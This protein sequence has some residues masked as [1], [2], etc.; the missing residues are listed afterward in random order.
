MDLSTL[1]SALNALVAL[2]IFADQSLCFT[3]KPFASRGPIVR[4]F[5]VNEDAKDGVSSVSADD[6]QSNSTASAQK[7]TTEFYLKG[8][9]RTVDY[10]VCFNCDD[11]PNGKRRRQNVVVR[12]PSSSEKEQIYRSNS[13]KDGVAIP[14]NKNNNVPSSFRDSLSKVF[15]PSFDPDN[16]VKKK[17]RQ[18]RLLDGRAYALKEPF[19]TENIT[20]PPNLEDLRAAPR[21][22]FEE[23]WIKRPFQFC[24]F[25][26]A[27][28][29]FPYLT[30]FLEYF[31]TMEPS[32]LD[33]I[34]S[35]FAPGRLGF[36]DSPYL[37]FTT[38]SSILSLLSLFLISFLFLQ[39]FPFYMVPLY[40]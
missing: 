40:L 38:S 36:A 3:L 17:A 1:M 28:F 7:M 13:S 11:I 24:I 4:L 18:T 35:K 5:T 19:A 6:T 14:K 26:T 33:D 12:A 27:Y 8:L 39:G 16:D 21:G 31:V 9:R 30:K 15:E 34:T 25:L 23:L 20:A 2:L 32:Q 10:P 22:R 37:F 29:I